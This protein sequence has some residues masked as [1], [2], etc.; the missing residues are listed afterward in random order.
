LDPEGAI[1]G[2]SAWSASA[3]GFVQS[4]HL[5]VPGPEK[6]GAHLVTSRQWDDMQLSLVLKSTEDGAI[7]V[8][9]RYLD[10]QNHYRFS[11]N[12]AESYRRL[13]KRVDGAMSVLWQDAT[14]FELDQVNRLSVRAKGGLILGFLDGQQL[15]SVIDHDISSGGVG[16]YTCGNGGASFEELRV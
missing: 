11:M 3:S 4:S 14:A 9:I 13:E 16:L 1:D 10:K 12:R 15:F 5:S 6:L 8:L 2:P 7:G